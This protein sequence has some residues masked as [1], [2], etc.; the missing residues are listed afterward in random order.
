M[1]FGI[2]AH[3]GP[4]GRDSP[5]IPAPLIRGMKSS[6]ELPTVALSALRHTVPQLTREAVD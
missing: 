2:V 6:H 5:R 4:R 1:S 3:Q